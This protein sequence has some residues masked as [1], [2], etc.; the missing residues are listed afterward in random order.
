MI[1]V[2]FRIIQL[3]NLLAKST[4]TSQGRLRVGRRLL[5]NDNV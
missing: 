4:V 5:I 1:I 3:L 2:S